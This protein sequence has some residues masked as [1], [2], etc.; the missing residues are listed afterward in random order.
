MDVRYVQEQTMPETEVIIIPATKSPKEKKKQGKRRVAAYCRVST[1]DEEQLTSY[2]VQIEH[3]TEVIESNPNWKFAG[4]FADEGITGVMA[5]KRDEFNRMIEL[6]REKKID[7]I[8]TKSISRFARNIVDSIKYIRELKALGISIYFEKENIDTGEMT[9]EMMVALYSVFAQA[10]SESTSN[11][12]KLGKRFNYKAG[13]VPM[14]YGNILGY[15]KG[16]DGK[17]EIIPEEAKIIEIIY[18]KFLDGYS[19]QGISEYLAKNGYKTKKGSSEWK[20]SAIQGILR[21]E[22]YRGDVLVQ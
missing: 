8:L 19:C 6:C 12:V 15:R 21:N 3:Y 13:N 11:N 1:D 18:T 17:P 4:I 16:K 22:K 10:E 7:H 20:R 2:N 5:K 9:S 14:M